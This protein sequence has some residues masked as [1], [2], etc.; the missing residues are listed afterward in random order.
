MDT[1]NKSKWQVRIA[2]LLIFVLGFAAGARALSAYKRFGRS[3]NAESREGRFAQTLEALKLTAE[4]KTQVDQILGDTR[5]QLQGLRKESE[6]RVA[7]IRRQ[8]DE[9]LQKVL[10]P[11]Q[12]TQFQQAREKMHN[13]DRRGGRGGRDDKE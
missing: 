9:R 11:E 6:P 7:E 3:I 2:A 10:T 1:T 8:A 12:W 13:R 4:Q 5:Q